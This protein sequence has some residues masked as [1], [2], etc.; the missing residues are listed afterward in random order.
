[1]LMENVKVTLNIPQFNG[2][3]RL[4]AVAYTQNRFGSAE[5]KMKVADDLIAEPQLP[6][7]FRAER[8]TGY[9]CHFD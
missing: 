8:F 2:E 5:S 1:M 7:F 4:M 3:V 9:A 6:R